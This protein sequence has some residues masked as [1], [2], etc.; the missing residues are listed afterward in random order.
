MLLLNF[1]REAERSTKYL[2]PLSS[3]RLLLG[4]FTL[5]VLSGC[6]S[7]RALNRAVVAYDAAVTSATSK[8]LLINIARPIAK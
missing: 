3:L 6:L 7:P 4:I 1:L 2:H 8:Q 5:V